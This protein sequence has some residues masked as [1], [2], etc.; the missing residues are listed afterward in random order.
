MPLLTPCGMCWAAERGGQLGDLERAG[1]RRRRSRWVGR[2]LDR[3]S[4]AS[5]ALVMSSGRAAAVWLKLAAVDQLIMGRIRGAGMT[6]LAS[7]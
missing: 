4:P 7:A 2:Q 3:R 6:L 5:P 1:G